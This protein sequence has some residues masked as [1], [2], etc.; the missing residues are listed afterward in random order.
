MTWFKDKQQFTDWAGPKVHYPF[1]PASFAQD[2]QIN[3]INSFAMVD[4][5]D[6]LIGFGQYYLRHNKC[7]LARLVIS[8]NRRGEGL[9]T[10][11]IQHLQ[12]DAKHSIGTIQ[13]S[14]FVY[15]HNIAAIKAYQ[16][17]GFEVAQYPDDS[18]S[19]CMYML[20]TP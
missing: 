1:T 20:T 13:S 15:Q 8:P 16:R 9:I 19:A 7:H 17:L 5:D 3:T 18:M 2:L 14:L 11:L 12:L 4:K 6:T 10:P